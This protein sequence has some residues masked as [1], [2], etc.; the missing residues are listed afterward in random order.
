[1]LG[2][3]IGC[4]VAAFLPHII[5]SLTNT[6]TSLQSQQ[7]QEKP[8]PENDMQTDAKAQR[9]VFGRRIDLVLKLVTYLFLQNPAENIAEYHSRIQ[10]FLNHLLTH[11]PWKDRGEMRQF[12]S[13]L[14]TDAALFLLNHCS[15]SQVNNM[16]SEERMEY[17]KMRLTQDILYD[18]L[19][20]MEHMA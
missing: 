19:L 1:M 18:A 9:V 6:K 12:L 13:G 20:L 14:H 16:T 4:I 3:V 2:I 7:Y 5:T 10:A 11:E 8:W 17:A 15:P